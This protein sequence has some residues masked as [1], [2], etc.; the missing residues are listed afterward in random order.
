MKRAT[1]V[2]VVA[3]LAVVILS[4]GTELLAAEPLPTIE[5]DV[6]P[7]SQPGTEP[8]TKPA[9]PLAIAKQKALEQYKKVLDRYMSSD[10]AGLKVEMARMRSTA[11]LPRSDKLDLAY[12]KRTIPEYRPLWWKHCR[13]ASNVSFRAKIWGRPFVANFMPTQPQGKRQAVQL[14]NNRIQIVAQWQPHMVDNPQPITGTLAV[15]HGLTRGHVGESIVWYE[16]GRNY[17]PTFLPV[18]QAVFLYQKQGTM[19]SHVQEFLAGMSSLYHSSPKARLAS[20]FMQIDPLKKNEGGSACTRAGHAVGAMIL[21]RVLT[22]PKQWPAFKLPTEVPKTMVELNTIL[23]VYN[24]IDPEWS[25]AE[26]KALRDLARVFVLTR[27]KAILKSKGTIV[28]SNKLSMKL[29]ATHDRQAQV[30]RDAWVAKK[31]K[32]IIEAAQKAKDKGKDKGASG[33]KSPPVKK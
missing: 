32:S 16:L 13:S 1:L 27:G 25:L 19:F 15:A 4:T 5:P 8:T 9:S 23:H 11:R 26:D 17:V 14:V 22:E 24:R 30:L 7:D 20:L 29:M 28:L 18:K 33:K 31:L 2:A 10:F 6:E 12:I 3:V 21:A